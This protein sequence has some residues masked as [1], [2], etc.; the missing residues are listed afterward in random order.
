MIN[1][2][3]TI[4][5]DF[6][7][8]RTLHGLR[9][10]NSKVT[11]GTRGDMLLFENELNNQLIGLLD[12]FT[13]I[14]QNVV[15]V[16]DSHSWRKKTEHYTPYYILQEEGNIEPLGYKANRTSVKE[17]DDIDWEM[18]KHCLDNFIDRIKT[19]TNLK[20]FKIDGLEGDDLLLLL[21]RKFN[22]EGIENVIFCSDGDLA[23]I[24]NSKTHVFRNNKSKECPD[25]TVIISKK[26]FDKKFGQQDVMSMFL[27]NSFDTELID[28]LCKLKLDAK[29]KLMAKREPNKQIVF[30]EP[31]KIAFIKSVIGDKKDNIFPILRWKSKTGTKNYKVTEKMML[32]VFSE[33]G[34][35]DINDTF[36]KEL[37]ANDDDFKTFFLNLVVETKQVGIAKNILVHFKHN[38]KVNTL[39]INN[40]PENYVTDFD[41]E[42]EK[43]KSEIIN[44]SEELMSLSSVGKVND[45]ATNILLNSTPDL[46]I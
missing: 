32:K 46:S 20:V 25:G 42:F 14:V 17:N 6:F 28:N 44:F 22:K 13:G 21:S 8:H 38:W 2:V 39:A 19:N 26:N 11:L 37:M 34:Y 33:L 43:E 36:I 29:N 27:S 40:I 9:I 3:L 16:F 5:G 35:K 31:L 1:K 15:F 24:V 23:Q 30:S 4:D 41:F 12:I 7:G 45:S 18:F 10:T